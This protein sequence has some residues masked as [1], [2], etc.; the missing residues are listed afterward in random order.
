MLSWVENLQFSHDRY[1]FQKCTHRFEKSRGESRGM[2]GFEPT[3]FFMKDAALSMKVP[4]LNSTRYRPP[5]RQIDALSYVDKNDIISL[6]MSLTSISKTSDNNWNNFYS[7]NTL[8]NPNRKSL[9]SITTFCLVEWINKPINF[10]C[11]VAL[12]SGDRGSALCF[13]IMCR[14]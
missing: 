2:L 5:I 9:W 8:S 14:T 4:S 1:Y 3:F 11:P 12:F 7:L 6:K 10:H 13:F